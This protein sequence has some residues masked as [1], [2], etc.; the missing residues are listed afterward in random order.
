MDIGMSLKFRFNSTARV[1]SQLSL[2]GHAGAPGRS[3][4]QLSGRS[5]SPSRA[6]EAG[7]GVWTGWGGRRR[8]RQRPGAGCAVGDPVVPRVARPLPA[9]APPTAPR[10]T[11]PPAAMQRARAGPGS[12]QGAQLGGWS[13]GGAPGAPGTWAQPRPPRPHPP[14][15]DTGH[16]LGDRG[17][18]QQGGARAPAA[19][20]P[21]PGCAEPRDGG[22]REGQVTGRRAVGEGK[23]STA[24][25]QAAPQPAV[26]AV[27]SSGA[28]R[29]V[30]YPP[31]SS[32]PLP[33]PPPGTSTPLL[34]TAQEPI[35]GL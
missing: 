22:G 17:P 7:N 26:P 31:P 1:S 14:R 30:Q 24:G 11:P 35:S 33:V 9:T 16:A 28:G 34:P 12:P 3:Q 13:P 23:G 21:S 19:G 4:G 8:G 18:E 25:M 6:R 15:G 10:V 32:S 2:H 20:T 27:A 29:E 5:A